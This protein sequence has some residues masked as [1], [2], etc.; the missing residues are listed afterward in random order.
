MLHEAKINVH[1]WF[2]C[3]EKKNLT[4][5]V[6]LQNYTC[7]CMMKTHYDTPKN[8]SFEAQQS[9]K[10]SYEAVSEQTTNV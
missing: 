8:V 6:K 4:I 2:F 10:I 3:I 7:S 5:N 1:L 9:M